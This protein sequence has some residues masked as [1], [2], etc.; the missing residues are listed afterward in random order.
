MSVDDL[1][2][3]YLEDVD[4]T[5]LAGTTIRHLLTH[6]HGLRQGG[7]MAA[8]SRPVRDW[9]YNNAGVNSARSRRPRVFGRPLAEVLR[10]RASGRSASRAR[11]GARSRRSAS[12]G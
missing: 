4:R 11:T 8:S 6:T 9:S 1:A 5:L 2:A 10:G 7:A 12:S 3:D